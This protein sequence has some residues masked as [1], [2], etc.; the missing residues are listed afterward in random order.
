LRAAVQASWQAGHAAVYLY[1]IGLAAIGVRKGR[2]TMA[3]LIYSA[4]MSLDG[5]VAD[6]GATFDWAAPDEEM[7]IFVNDLERPVGTY[8]Y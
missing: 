3:G 8:H 7:H 1:L 6:Q 2:A 4:I 5:Y